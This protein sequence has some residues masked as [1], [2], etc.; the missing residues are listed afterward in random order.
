VREAAFQLLAVA[1]LN[2]GDTPVGE[3]P[4]KGGETRMEPCK[5]K[6]RGKYRP[7]KV[8]G[9]ILGQ[10]AWTRLCLAVSSARNTRLEYAPLHREF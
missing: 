10:A 8:P 9:T 5:S 6:P 7:A 1:L 4:N 2:H 3:L